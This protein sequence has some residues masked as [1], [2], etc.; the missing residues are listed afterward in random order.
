MKQRQINSW[1]KDERVGIALL[2][3]AKTF[4]PSIPYI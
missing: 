2:A 4:W 1:L 3:E